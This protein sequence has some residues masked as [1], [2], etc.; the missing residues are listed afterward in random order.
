MNNPG[1]YHMPFG[2]YHAIQLS[3]IA[4]FPEGLAYLERMAAVLD[5]L[6]EIKAFLEYREEMLKAKEQAAT[7]T[8]PNSQV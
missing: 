3:R 7:E 1:D 2:R 4:A 8:A 5:D 6:P